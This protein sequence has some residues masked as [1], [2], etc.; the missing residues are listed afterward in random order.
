MSE[1]FDLKL[2]EETLAL[3]NRPD[4]CYKALSLMA[5]ALEEI[6]TVREDRDFYQR[7]FKLLGNTRKK[8][9]PYCV[10]HKDL[11]KSDDIRTAR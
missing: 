10:W 11:G 4:Q 3:A 7:A 1:A 6:K 9:C 5:S 8:D 2:A